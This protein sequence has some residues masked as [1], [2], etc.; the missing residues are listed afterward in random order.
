MKKYYSKD[1][2]LVVMSGG[3]ETKMVILSELY[4]QL[5]SISM[6]LIRMN[7]LEI[8]LPQMYKSW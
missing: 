5:K 7:S 1:E 6:T 2:T 3:G 4:S 8:L